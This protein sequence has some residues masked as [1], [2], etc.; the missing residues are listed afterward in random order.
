MRKK[1]LQLFL[2]LLLS[3]F[4]YGASA[5]VGS[6]SLSP[7]KLEP[8]NCQEISKITLN[9]YSKETDVVYQVQPKL[10]QQVNGEDIYVDSA[11]LLVT[12]L[13]IHVTPNSKQIVRIGFKDNCPINNDIEKTYR[14][15]FT[16]IPLKPV[17][18]K[19][20]QKHIINF[21]LNFSIP[22]YLQ[23]QQVVTE[24]TWQLS[25]I[26]EHI[27]KLTLTN[28]GSSHINILQMI[29]MNLDNKKLEINTNNVM[30][31]VLAQQKKSW[32]LQVP[33]TS[34]LPNQ[35]NVVAKSNVG[36]FNEIVNIK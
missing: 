11:D 36:D 3:L 25:K 31:V 30:G 12:P 4:S 14:L 2:A 18:T 29:F 26:N 6:I 27:L 17:T 8:K 28:Q 9:N 23:P 10:W 32:L 1:H 21:T 19:K 20:D 34:K 16:Q 24:K 13:L 35:I 22:I 15:L 7:T 33:S 5:E